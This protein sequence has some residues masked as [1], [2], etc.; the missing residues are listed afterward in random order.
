MTEVTKC[1]DKE[2]IGYLIWKI[3]KFWQR[4]KHRVLDEYGITVSQME[5]L[6]A[7]F[8]RKK[9]QKKEEVTQVALSQDTDIDPMTVSTIL[10]NL[11][12]KGLVTRKESETDTRARAVD[13][14]EAGNALLLKAIEKLKIEHEQLFRD[15]DKDALRK[16]LRIL[17]DELDKNKK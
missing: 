1:T 17:L 15:V 9:H 13:L 5:I 2:D 14:T 6:G 3:A 7:I 4:G 12:K 16:Q 11:Q 10:R 8:K